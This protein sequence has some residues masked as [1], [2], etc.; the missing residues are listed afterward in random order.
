VQNLFDL[1]VDFKRLDPKTPGLTE[2]IVDYIKHL[3]VSNDQLNDLSQ[4]ILS[5][6]NFNP[7]Y[8]ILILS[9]FAPFIS[10]LLSIDVSV[11]E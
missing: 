3:G 7:Q 9:Q 4:Y 11:W 5:P 10:H 8:F 2:G 1:V 6:S